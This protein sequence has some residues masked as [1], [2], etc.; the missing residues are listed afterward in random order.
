M[1]RTV[2]PE[3]YLIPERALIACEPFG[4]RLGARAAARA[5]AA[6]LTA[7]GLPEPDVCE[8]D[9]ARGEAVGTTLAALGFDARMRRARALIV[10]APRLAQHELVGGIVFE[11]A[12]RARQAGVPAY[13]IA[14]AN[15]LDAFDARV[16]DL[17]VI[18]EGSGPR[19]LTAAAARLAAL[20]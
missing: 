17:Q 6:G 9:G 13:A 20:I 14:A 5:I 11:I 3:R 10:A 2:I 8:L 15:L 18:V 4:A 19:G 7:A 16:L 12:T 1:P